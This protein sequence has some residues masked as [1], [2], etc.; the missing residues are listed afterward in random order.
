MVCTHFIWSFPPFGSICS[1]LKDWYLYGVSLHLILYALLWKVDI[2]GVSLHVVPFCSSMK[3]MLLLEFS[4]PNSDNLIQFE[5]NM[6]LYPHNPFFW[7]SYFDQQVSPFTLFSYINVIMICI[8]HCLDRESCKLWCCSPLA[9][10]VM[11]H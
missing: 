9:C 3:R 8:L 6:L 4:P 2:Y 7:L 11:I 10:C 5:G 1:T